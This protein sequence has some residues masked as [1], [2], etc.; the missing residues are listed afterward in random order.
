LMAVP[1]LPEMVPEL[2]MAPRKV[3]TTEPTTMPVWPLMVPL[4][5]MPPENV[6][7]V[8][9]ARLPVAAPPMKMPL[10]PAEMVP[11]LLIPPAKAEIVMNAAMPPRRWHCRR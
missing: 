7:I 6:E 4:F 9:D 3:W 10:P 8:T 1:P 11:E 5:V 2:T